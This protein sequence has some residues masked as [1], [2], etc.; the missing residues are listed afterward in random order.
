LDVIHS[1]AKNFSHNRY[2]WVAAVMAAVVLSAGSCQFKDISPVTGE[3]ATR[4]ELLEH[5][6]TAAEAEATSEQLR[7][8]ELTGE[9]KAIEASYADQVRIL[10]FKANQSSQ[11]AQDKIA[12]FQRKVAIA[13]ENI[14]RKES[15]VSGVMEFTKGVIV[16]I[17]PTFGGMATVGL[18][19]ISAG[20]FGDNRRK[21]AVINEQKAQLHPT[22]I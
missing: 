3:R 21:N 11:T 7:R 1:I 2:T 9:I 17:D 20:L 6:T 10:T 13:V 18:G 12:S 14:E 19:L 15:L 16:S 5:L 8:A 4:A 22:P